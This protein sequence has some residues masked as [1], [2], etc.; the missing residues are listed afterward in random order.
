MQL[1][2]HEHLFQLLGGLFR[3]PPHAERIRL[4][5]QGNAVQELFSAIGK[6]NPGELDRSGIGKNRTKESERLTC[7]PSELLRR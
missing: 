5:F 2:S 1:V 7:I 4:V 6:G 3:Q